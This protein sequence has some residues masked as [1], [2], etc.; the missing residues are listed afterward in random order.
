MCVSVRACVRVIHCPVISTKEQTACSEIRW[1]PSSF[2]RCWMVVMMMMYPFRSATH[3]RRVPLSCRQVCALE[4]RPLA[5]DWRFGRGTAV[6]T[7]TAAN[8][9]SLFSHKIHRSCL[10]K[11][12]FVRSAVP[13]FATTSKPIRFIESLTGFFY[14]TSYRVFP[15]FL[16]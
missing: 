7:R 10:F 9:C 12:F 2:T 15:F 16:C 5:D 11:F 4:K 13:L 1:L 3:N 8:D 6:R 14:Q